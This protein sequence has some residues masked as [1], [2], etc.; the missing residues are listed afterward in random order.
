MK[1]FG[2]IFAIFIAI[3]VAYLFPQGIELLPLKTITDI[4]IGLIF[5]FYGLK[6][7]P[8]E[9][10]AGLFNYK[11]HIVIQLT[12]FIIFPVLCLLCLP[13]FE[14]GLRSEL[15][16][17]L[18]F[19]GTLPSTVSSSV[20]MVALAK[21]NL[22]VAIFNASLS[23]LIGIFATPLWI[24]FILEKTTDFDFLIVLQKLCLQIIVPLII[25]LFLQ[26]YFGHLA[27]KYGRQLSLFDKTTIILII[28]SSFSNS[29]TSDL[30]KSIEIGELLKM[31]GIVL[32]LFFTV[33]FGLAYFSKFLG[34]NTED[35]IATQFCGTKKSL[36]HGSVMVRVIFGNSANSGLL[37]LPIML[38]HSA[39]L[40]LVAWFAEKYRKREMGE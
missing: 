13:L 10:K 27:R 9:F 18:F 15:W 17:A 34:F 6:L 40:I 8:T 16:I 11:V 26:R 36:V 4:G 23:G 2:F 28:Y 25:G 19:L 29:F 31:A 5:F 7:S 22:P 30:I 32:I 35:K 14:E 33:F 21:G 37:L 39:Q 12:T 24:G 38:Y 20:V 1:S 3:G